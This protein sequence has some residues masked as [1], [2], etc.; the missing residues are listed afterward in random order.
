VIIDDRLPTIDGKLVGIQVQNSEFWGA[1]LEKAYAKF[2]GSY[3]VIDGIS[4]TQAM[5]DFTGEDIT[6][7]TSDLKPEV[8]D[9]KPEIIEMVAQPQVR[10]TVVQ[11]DSHLASSELVDIDRLPRNIKIAKKYNEP[12]Q[13]N[14][15]CEC[16]YFV[17]IIFFGLSL[18]V[19]FLSKFF[20]RAT[21]KK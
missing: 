15:F 2:H 16:V 7:T 1:L 3:G 11:R 9:I 10:E 20:V 13:Q 17:I 19:F 4:S 21:P 8:T 14:I 5:S 12:P 6:I 18:S